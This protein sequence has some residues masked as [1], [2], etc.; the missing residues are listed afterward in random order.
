MRSGLLTMIGFGLVA[1]SVFAQS[2]AT[3]M[4][5]KKGWLADL[6]KG[7]AE[8]RRT[9]KPLMVAIRCDP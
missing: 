8:A 4:M 7:Q 9:G 5:A 3:R 1:S 2:P 6:G